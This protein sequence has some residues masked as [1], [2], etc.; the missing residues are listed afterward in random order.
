MPPMPES[1]DVTRD[2]YDSGDAD[3]FYFRIWG[4][5]DIHVG[6]Y[7]S[8]E[9]SIFDASRR[10]VE[11]MAKHISHI[12]KGS[13]VLDVGA[14]YGG[15]ARFLA[16]EFDFHVTC[17]NLSTVQNRRNREMNREAGLEDR[18]EVVD[19]NFEELP[20]ANESFALI[21]CQDSILHSSRKKRVFEEINRVMKPGAEFIFT[22]PMQQPG[23]DPVLLEPVLRRIHL[24]SMGSIEQ[25]R[26]FADELGW[27]TVNIEPGPECLVQHYSSVLKN[28]E[29][30]E[31]SLGGSISPT[32]IENMKNGLRHWITAG[33]RGVL[34]WGILHFQKP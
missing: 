4:G 8:E 20:F 7:Q 17:L 3:E 18:I 6:M 27:K 16:R 28:L 29:G 9:E 33:G 34:D 1:V 14:G 15:A 24:E 21:W 23:A 5:E 26:Q 2:Y 19:G 22:D 11:T 25:Y 10:T 31:G 12:P 13:R 30:R 32:Y